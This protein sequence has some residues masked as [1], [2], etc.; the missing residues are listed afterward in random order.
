MRFFPLEAMPSA[1][2]S[3]ILAIQHLVQRDVTFAPDVSNSN[4]SRSKPSSNVLRFAGDFTHLMIALCRALNSPARVGQVPTMVLTALGP[5]DL[6][7]YAEAY[8]GNR[9][10]LFD[11]LR[12]L[13]FQRGSFGS[14]TPRRGAVTS[15]APL[16][17]SRLH[18][19]PARCCLASC[20]DALSTMQPSASAFKWSCRG[21]RGTSSLSETSKPAQPIQD[22]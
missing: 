14:R 6:Q 10:Y 1:Y 4:T 15:K 11:P 18:K 17:V 7:T 21:A 5:P 9:W 16:V 8:L 12:G 20:R 22:L 2:P 3:R 19:A 13:A